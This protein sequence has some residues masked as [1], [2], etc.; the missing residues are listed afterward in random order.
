MSKFREELRMGIEHESRKAL[1]RIE[2]VS[3]SLRR[4]CRGKL[5]VA[6]RWK[7]KRGKKE[8]Y[9]KTRTLPRRLSDHFVGRQTKTIT[10]TICFDKVLF[11][12]TETLGKILYNTTKRSRCS[13][14]VFKFFHAVADRVEKFP[15]P[16]V[17]KFILKRFIFKKKTKKRKD[18]RSI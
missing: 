7:G 9:D 16:T 14:F 13:V 4:N 12:Q 6:C 3:K 8:V 17:R 18:L 11:R 1:S 15:L 2:R 10:I 5:R